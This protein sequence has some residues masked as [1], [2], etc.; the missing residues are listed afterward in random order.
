MMRKPSARPGGTIRPSA[1]EPFI[2]GFLVEKEGMPHYFSRPC[3]LAM[4][5]DGSLRIGDDANGMLYRVSYGGGGQS[6]ATR[7]A[8]TRPGERGI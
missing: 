3:G 6:P 2:T 8:A 7:P 1:F 4:A 5:R